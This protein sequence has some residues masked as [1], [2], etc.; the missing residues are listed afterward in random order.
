MH[1][2]INEGI[3]IRVQ[4]RYEILDSGNRAGDKSDPVWGEGAGKSTT[5]LYL[6]LEHLGR[7]TEPR[8]TD[9]DLASGWE[10]GKMDRLDKLS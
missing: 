6:Q 9:A 8:N 10:P 7:C 1:K 4:I 2:E 5:L 3:I